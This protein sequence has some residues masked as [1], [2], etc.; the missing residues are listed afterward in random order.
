MQAWSINTESGLAGVSLFSQ[1]VTS[2]ILVNINTKKGGMDEIG[3][4]L[5]VHATPMSH[6]NSFFWKKKVGFFLR[7]QTKS[8]LELLYTGNHV[9]N[10]M[11]LFAHMYSL[12]TYYNQF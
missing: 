3:L 8:G 4:V 5:L 11:A 1:G 2:V 12:Y 6:P 7:G 9:K 10:G